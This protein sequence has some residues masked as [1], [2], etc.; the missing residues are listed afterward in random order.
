MKTGIVLEGGGMRGIYVAG[1]LDVF[2][3]NSLVT[4]GVIGVSAGAIHGVSYVSGQIGR[5][6]RY[7]KKYARDKRFMSL[8]SLITTGEIVGREFCYE[9]IPDRLDPFDYE[10][11]SS[12]PTDF[13]AT[14]TNVETGNAEYVHCKDLH[15]DM[16]YVRASASLPCV[17]KIVEAG[18]LKLLDGGVADSIPVEAF[19]KMGYRK[20]IIVLTRPRNYQKKPENILASRILYKKYPKLVEAIKKRHIHYNATLEKI[21]SLE[22]NGE[23]IVVAPG[24]GVQI[25]RLEKN[26]DKIQWMYDLGRQDALEKLEEIRNFLQ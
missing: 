22:K 16:D 1:V 8:Y 2:M 9:A 10:A 14:C 4:D 19:R 7:Y 6:I 17:S 11:F 26:L 25:S 5:S 13:F 15:K 21:R 23:A 24:E 3:E 18:G 20:N 12:S